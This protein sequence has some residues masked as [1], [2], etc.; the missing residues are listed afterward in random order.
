MRGL[1]DLLPRVLRFRLRLLRYN[2]EDVHVPGKKVSQQE[3][4]MI[5]CHSI[6]PTT[7]KIG[8]CVCV[9]CGIVI[10]QSLRGEIM[11]YL[12]E[13]PQRDLQMPCQSPGISVVARYLCP[14][15]TDSR[16]MWNIPETQN[17]VQRVT[18]PDK[19]PR[20]TLAKGGDGIIWVV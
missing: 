19:S 9:F 5:H 7:R 16:Q 11:N 2:Y 3:A 17:T 8:P 18:D 10:P 13:G 1:E 6:W 20:P 4:P 12:H 15:Q 14:S